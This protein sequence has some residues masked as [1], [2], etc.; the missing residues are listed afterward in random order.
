[1]GRWWQRG[2]HCQLLARRSHGTQAAPPTHPSRTD[3]A[4]TAPSKP[5]TG[6]YYAWGDYLAQIAQPFGS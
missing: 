2:L 4:L 1:M 3:P 6:A 5:E